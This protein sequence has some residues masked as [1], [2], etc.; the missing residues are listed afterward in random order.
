MVA[1]KNTYT[2]TVPVDTPAWMKKSHQAPSHMIPL[3]GFYEIFASFLSLPLFFFLILLS[4]NLLKITFFKTVSEST[5][6]T[7]TAKRKKTK[8][9]R[10]QKKNQVLI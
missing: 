5:P 6:K 2:M 3:L 9:I 1:L 4:F 10:Y 8:K 7:V